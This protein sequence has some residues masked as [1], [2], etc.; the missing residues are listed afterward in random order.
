MSG[1]F[2]LTSNGL[3]NVHEVKLEDGRVI[4]CGMRLDRVVDKR[5]K[6]SETFDFLSN[7]IFQY[8]MLHL[9]YNKFYKTLDVF[10]KKT[11]S[12]GFYN[13]DTLT[14]YFMD[15]NKKD[16]ECITV[17]EKSSTLM[18][19]PFPRRIEVK[20]HYYSD[21]LDYNYSLNFGKTP[22]L[23]IGQEWIPPVEAMVFEKISFLFFLYCLEQTN[24]LF[25]L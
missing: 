9:K 1:T 23:D 12:G 4:R 14:F 16:Q 15:K 17:A 13:K 6:V 20:G 22:N 25:F 24:C 3:V 2:Y 11:S 10:A 7:L 21:E 8:Y 5:Y 18:P 19:E